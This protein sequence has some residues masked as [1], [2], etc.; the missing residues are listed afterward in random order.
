MNLLILDV[1]HSPNQVDA[2]GLRDQNIG[3]NQIRKPGAMLCFGAKWHGAPEDE[4]IFDSVHQSTRK[5]MVNHLH[6]LFTDADV[7]LGYNS[8]SYDT[9]VVNR[10]FILQG[11]RP[12]APYKQV[13][14]LRAMRQ[15]FRFASN[16]LD[17]VAQQ[18][19][20][21]AKTAHM[22]HTLWSLC[23]AGDPAAWALMKKY[24]I[25]DVLLTEKLYDRVLPWVKNHPSHG[26]IDEAKKCCPNCGGFKLQRRGYARTVANKYVRFQCMGCGTWSREAFTENTRHDR[27]DIIR[28]A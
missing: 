7:I 14:L 3:I 8:T 15:N 27:E 10:E 21:G 2:W 5:R 25:Q 18:L 19:G 6:A 4:V 17:F 28:Q 24:N 12:P 26:S 20:L 22:G 16:K 11:L 1:E 13:D 23:E 9:K